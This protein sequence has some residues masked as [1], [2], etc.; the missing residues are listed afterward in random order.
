MLTF[1]VYFSAF[2]A[3]FEAGNFLLSSGEDKD[4]IG[5]LYGTHRGRR[6]MH[7]RF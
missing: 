3:S 1:S 7:T 6:E 5:R 4:E 2:G